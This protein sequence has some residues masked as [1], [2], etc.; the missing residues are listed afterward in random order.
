MARRR[1]TLR[2]D[3]GGGGGGGTRIS[4]TITQQS[5][6][7]SPIFF[8][9]GPFPSFPRFLEHETVCCP[10]PPSDSAEGRREQPLVDWSRLFRLSFVVKPFRCGRGGKQKYLY[11]A[12]EW[13]RARRNFLVGC[14]ICLWCHPHIRVAPHYKKTLEAA[15]VYIAT[16]AFFSFSTH[17]LL[18]RSLLSASPPPFLF[19]HQYLEDGPP[20]E[21]RRKK[22]PFLSL[23]CGS[24]SC[25]FS[26]PPPPPTRKEDRG[27]SLP[28]FLFPS[29]SR[30]V[31][32]RPPAREGVEAHGRGKGRKKHSK[33]VLN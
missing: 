16:R 21:R 26:L 24:L 4:I 33:S 11:R 6:L 20:T 10:Q 22:A 19:A 25:P 13:K 15:R 14:S 5:R 12:R 29:L 3:G 2:A 30:A 27:R 32:K 7:P 18:W 1:W 31:R 9:G 23:P 17:H 8:L 28:F